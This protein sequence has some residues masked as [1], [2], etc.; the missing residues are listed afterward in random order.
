[1]C[2][3]QMAPENC[4]KVD[5]TLWDFVSKERIDFSDE[6]VHQS[7]DGLEQPRMHAL[8]LWIAFNCF[9]VWPP[10]WVSGACMHAP[11]VCI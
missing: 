5:C 6:A 3:T 8:L 7:S 11:V 10:V 4:I 9:L 2:S 1:M